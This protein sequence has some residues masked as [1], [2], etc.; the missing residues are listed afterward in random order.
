[1]IFIPSKMEWDDLLNAKFII[2]I[3]A[4]NRCILLSNLVY[5]INNKQ[6]NHMVD[7][8]RLLFHLVAAEK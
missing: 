8:F 4:F 3:E 6:K 5:L 2:K 7:W 1:M